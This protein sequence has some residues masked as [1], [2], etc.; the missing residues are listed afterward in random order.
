MSSLNYTLQ[1]LHIKSSL[2]S[3][4]LAT[5]FFTASHAELNSQL[6]SSALTPR[7]SKLCYD[8]RSVGQSVLVSSIHLGRTTRYLL[9][10]D[11][12][13]FVDVGR[14]LWLEN[15]SAVYNCCWVS[16]AQSFV[17]PSPAVLVTIFYCL[18]YETP[19]TWRA[20]SPYLC[21]PGTA[22]PSYTIRHWVPISSPPT[23][24]RTTVEVFEP[25]STHSS[26][27]VEPLI[28]LLHGPHRKPLLFL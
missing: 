14:S 15:G 7:K 5:N 17:G 21:P 4:P 9:L 18:R 13:G 24:R 27:I 2:H 6:N 26:V 28:I 16:P 22:W 11:S 12:C 8:R 19:P 3:R 1:I 25:A 20:S 10:S 23:T